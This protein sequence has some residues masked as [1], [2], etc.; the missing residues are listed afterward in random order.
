MNICRICMANATGGLV[1]IFSKLEDAFIANIIVECTAVQILEDDGLPTAICQPCI[2]DLKRMISFIKRARDSDRKLRKIFLETSTKTDGEQT[3]GETTNW[4]SN[5]QTL[6]VFADEIKAE[7]DSD[8]D[9][10]AF[11]DDGPSGQEEVANGSDW[12]SDGSSDAKP[13]KKRGRKARKN[14]YRE[15]D[16]D[17]NYDSDSLVKRMK[18]TKKRGRKAAC[19]VEDDDDNY[20]KEDVLDDKELATYKIVVVGKNQLICC[21]CLQVF[22]SQTDLQAHG[23]KNHVKKRRVNTSKTNICEICFRRYSTSAALRTHLRRVAEATKIYN[24]NKCTARFIDQSR[25]RQHAHHHPRDKEIVPSK[26]IVAP[27]PVVVQEEYGRICCA[28]ACYQSFE[29]EELLIAHAHTAH[30]MNKVEQSLDEN[31]DKPI[32]CPVCFKRFY[33]EISLQRHQQ[34]NYK[35]LS[36]QCSVCGLKVR[37][38][39]ALATHERSHRNE[40]PFECEVCHKN[41]T[42]KGS[43]KAHMMVHSGE[44]PFVCSTCGWSFRRKRNLQVHV[45]SHTNN[46]PFQCEICQ[47]A[48]KSKVHLQYHMRTHTGEKPYP[49]RFCEKAFA[50]HTNRQR[51]EMSHTGIK[52]YKCCYCDKTFIRKRFQVDHESSHTGVKPYR[53]EMC[54]RTFSQKTALRRHLQSHPLA[55]ENEIALAAPSPM[56]GSATMTTDDANMSPAVAP[57]TQVELKPL[58]CEPGPTNTGG[59]FQHPRNLSINLHPTV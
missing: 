14:R 43:L 13:A 15:S 25:R 46:Q 40:K 34:R 39:E 54:N 26:V 7:V 22:D 21:A 11:K 29:T 19:K 32:E 17:S 27:I 47:K 30:K 9:Q 31:R 44:K 28:Q 23:E 52:P 50:D 20:D 6:A 53:C 10:T 1:P 18:K 8:E 5:V 49:C 45:L 55:P 2:G 58:L 57:A 38:G 36:H 56:P 59:Y 51:H 4:E 42:S 33:D 12:K 16:D 24:C 35:P 41:F 37:G 3:A 48:F